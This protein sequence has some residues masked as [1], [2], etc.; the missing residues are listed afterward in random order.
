MHCSQHIPWVVAVVCYCWMYW[1]FLICIFAY[2]YHVFL[3]LFSLRSLCVQQKKKQQENACKKSTK[4]YISIYTFKAFVWS[5]VNLMC[6]G[7]HRTL[8]D[9]FHHG[10]FLSKLYTE[11]KKKNANKIKVLAVEQMV[12]I[13]NLCVLVTVCKQH[14]FFLFF[15]FPIQ[16]FIMC[17]IYILQQQRHKQLNNTNVFFS[18]FFIYSQIYEFLL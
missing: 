15:C 9:L 17:N 12:N 4:V 11:K 14:F 10:G 5:K 2:L 1:H 3:F 8:Y 6:I 18:F 13:V 7:N 16:I